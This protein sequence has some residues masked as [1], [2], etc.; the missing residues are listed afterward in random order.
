V[1][2]AKPDFDQDARFCLAPHEQAQ[3]GF[4]RASEAIKP[5]LR[6]SSCLWFLNQMGCEPPFCFPL[7]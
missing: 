1:K 3:S 4:R 5:G 6:L 2:P 7:I